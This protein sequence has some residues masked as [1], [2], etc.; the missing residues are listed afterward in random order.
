MNSMISPQHKAKIKWHCRRGMLE[1][2]LLLNQ[3]L[4]RYFDDLTEEQVGSFEQLLE[5]SDP[6]LYAVLLGNKQPEDRNL[7]EIVKLIKFHH[8]S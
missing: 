5:F 7:K 6:E 8:H 1:L 2:D 3:F 4:T